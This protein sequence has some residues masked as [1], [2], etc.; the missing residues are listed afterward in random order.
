MFLRCSIVGLLPLLANVLALPHDE[1]SAAPTVAGI[2]KT[3]VVTVTQTI[4]SSSTLSISPVPTDYSLICSTPNTPCIIDGIAIWPN[5]TKTLIVPTFTFAP[6]DSS[7]L[8]TAPSNN[9]TSLN[10]SPAV[11]TG[12]G[13]T[14]TTCIHTMARI[15]PGTDNN[16][17]PIPAL[18]ALLPTNDKPKVSKKAIGVVSPTLPPLASIVG[19]PEAE[20]DI[21]VKTSTVGLVAWADT[22]NTPKSRSK[23]VMKKQN[24]FWKHSFVAAHARERI[25]STGDGDEGGKIEKD[26]CM[27]CEAG[28]DVVCIGDTHYG[29]CDEGCAEPR[30]L[31]EGVKCVDGRIYGVR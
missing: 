5:G 9:T 17:G 22:D 7:T 20:D 24:R 14:S 30:K 19:A 15:V 27:T 10:R 18:T 28:R 26:D 11:S 8:G 3:V 13:T 12:L 16:L 6:S 31:K 23:Q 29:Y 21:V 4:N 25:E 1:D 2:A